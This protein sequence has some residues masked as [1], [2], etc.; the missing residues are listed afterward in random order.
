MRNANASDFRS[1]SHEGAEA[2]NLP[3]NAEQSWHFSIRFLT[4]CPSCAKTKVA[5]LPAFGELGR[6]ETMANWRR[7]ALILGGLVVVGVLMTWQFLPS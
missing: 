4:Y 6:C 2:Q 3:P 5:F 7:F 1:V